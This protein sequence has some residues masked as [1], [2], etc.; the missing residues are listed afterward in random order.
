MTDLPP[1]NSMEHSL[2][3]LSKWKSYPHFTAPEDP[4]SRSW[5]PVTGRYPKPHECGPSLRYLFKITFNIILAS[6]PMS[7]KLCLPFRLSRANPTY[8]Y[9]LSHACQRR[10]PLCPNNVWWTANPMS[11]SFCNFIPL[12]PNSVAS[13][14]FSNTIG[15]CS[16]IMQDL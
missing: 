1:F 8:V 16:S 6:T 15:L 9:F 2:Q 11:N 5:R 3:F 12:S 14:L 4:S 13:I 10:H 7:S